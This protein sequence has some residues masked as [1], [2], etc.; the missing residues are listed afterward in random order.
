[1]HAT[2]L[3]CTFILGILV[4]G[5]GF[6]VSWLRFAE[7]R[8][9][10]YADDPRNLLHRVVRAHGNAIEYAPFLAVLF[11]YLGSGPA[12]GATLWL[13]LGATASRVLH[14][15]GM[16]AWPSIAKPN[17]ARFV[18]ALGAY[19]CGLALCLRLVLVF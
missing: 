4:F 15:I 16:L 2:A 13:I 5:L 18:G 11:L 1:M 14:A 7:K 9:F 8:S 10:G 12:T 3:V 6:A 17:P 19:V